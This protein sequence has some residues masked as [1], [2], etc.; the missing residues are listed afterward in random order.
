MAIIALDPIAIQILRLVKEDKTLREMRAL[1]GIK[2]VSTMHDKMQGLV[3]MG[4]V[5]EQGEGRNK[6]R[7]LTDEG[8]WAID[9]LGKGEVRG[10]DNITGN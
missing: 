8:R 4:L 2:S 5:I 1:T 9:L 10:P 7:N 6:T 3:K